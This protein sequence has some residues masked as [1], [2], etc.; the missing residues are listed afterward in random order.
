MTPQQIGLTGLLLSALSAATAEVSDVHQWS[1]G[2]ELGLARASTPLD[3]WVDGGIGKLRYAG[4]D[5]GLVARRWYGEYSGRI[6]PTLTAHATAD[7]VADASRGFDITE[8]YLERRP[9][10]RSPN[11]QRWRFGLF[12]APWSLENTG[13]GWTT[14][15]TLSPSVVN[16]WIGEELRPLGAE[17]SL[18]RRVGG[19]G[20]QHRLSAHAAA[21]FG[22]DPAGSLLVWKGWSIHD[23]QSRFGDKLPLA[24][25]PQLQP[26][27]MF[28]LQDPH[29]APWREVDDRLGYY[30]GADWRYGRRALV[31]LAHYDNR[32]D[33]MQIESGQYAWH[34][35]FEQL[36]T[37]IEL[38]GGFGLLA[39][40]MTGSTV[41]GPVLVTARAV[42]TDFEARY[43]LLTKL[44]AKHRVSIRYDDFNVVDND[45]VPNDDNSDSGRAWTFAYRYKHSARWSLGAE[46]LRIASW[47]PAW[48]YFGAAAHETERLVQLQVGIRLG[49]P[50]L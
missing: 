42:D 36:A 21:F 15:F 47:H 33:P 31:A 27:T 46:W 23:R 48:Q 50:S 32:A 43:V 3:P 28:E 41:M 14:P 4:D 25:L 9:I 40:W 37:Q 29:V 34:T 39:Q 35:R 13:P 8:A 30:V 19:L 7:V 45:L 1:V 24:P 5:R 38:P 10:P 22:N 49:A 17:W 18:E 2:V 16:T 6:G 12:H 11:R 26:G 44:I 20:S